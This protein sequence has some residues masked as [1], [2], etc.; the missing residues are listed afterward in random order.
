MSQNSTSWSMRNAHAKIIPSVFSSMIPFKTQN[1]Y[2]RWHTDPFKNTFLSFSKE[3]PPSFHISLQS[4]LLPA[5]LD[6]TLL[7]QIP[8]LALQCSCH[9]TSNYTHFQREKAS[10]DRTY[11]PDIYT[12]GIH[13]CHAVFKTE[14]SIWNKCIY[15]VTVPCLDRLSDFQ[16]TITWH[17]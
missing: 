14:N 5:P 12:H 16:E 15:H 2:Q 9:I 10:K 1:Q 11:I 17:W 13:E 6:D 7:L 4:C 8:H 3:V